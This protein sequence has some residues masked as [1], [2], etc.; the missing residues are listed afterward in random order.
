M[1]W[2]QRRNWLRGTMRDRCPEHHLL[3]LE[4]ICT[5]ERVIQSNVRETKLKSPDYKVRAT[6]A[7]VVLRGVLAR[8]KHRYCS[9]AAAAAART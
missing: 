6:T 1:G 7:G 9:A 3:F 4:S 5:D 8:P 2:L